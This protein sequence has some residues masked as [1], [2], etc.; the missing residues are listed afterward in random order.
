MIEMDYL[1]D[2]ET[3][4]FR[5]RIMK[6]ITM[7]PLG[8]VRTQCAP[9]GDAQWP[10]EGIEWVLNHDETEWIVRE[11]ETQ[12]PP[13]PPDPTLQDLQAKAIKKVERAR[14]VW[15]KRG[16]RW[17]SPDGAEDVIQ[18]RDQQD[19]TNLLAV[20]GRAN[21]L[22][23]DGIDGSVIPF[24]AE[25]NTTYL[26]TANEALAMTSAAFDYGQLCYQQMWALKAAIEAAE[27]VAEVQSIE[28][29]AELS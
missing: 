17:N 13:V 15:F 12:E 1:R 26:L 24:R 21:A 8:M 25:S 10:P 14:A 9:P 29:E 22:K 4:V 19:I 27:T 20:Q 23:A 7:T 2:A 11:I 28:T 18:T 3:R 5:G 16:C 6:A